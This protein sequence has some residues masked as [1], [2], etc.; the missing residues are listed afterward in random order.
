MAE[1][2]VS[3]NSVKINDLLIKDN[4]TVK[5]INE[6]EEKDREDHLIKSI[7]IG[8]N[9]LRNTITVEKIDYI[10]KEFQRLLTAFSKRTDE[11]DDQISDT[12]EDSVTLMTESMDASLDLEK[13]GNPLYRL[14]KAIDNQITDLRDLIHKKEG[15][16]E[17]IDEESAKGTMKGFDFEDEVVDDL[18]F[19]Q[20]YPDSFEVIGD[21]AEGK[22]R[23]KVGDVLA[24]LQDGRTIAIEVKAGKNYSDRGDK[25]L[26][27]QMDQSMAYRS[28]VGSIAV[29]TIEAMESKVWQNSI[30]LDRGKNRFI[31]AVDR[32]NRDFTM[33]RVAYILLRERILASSE[34]VDT[35]ERKIIDPSKV[36]EIIEDIVRDMSSATKMRQILTDIEGRIFAVKEEISNYQGKV[37]GRVDELNQL[38]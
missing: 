12:M 14:K 35:A 8:I 13:E 34:N 19:W 21:K 38:L 17:G 15:K 33:L 22:T 5:V 28:S 23:R 2:I 37:Q 24:T 36:R 26:D 29:T 1:I 4:D 25:S 6:I 18:N 10:E 20:H 32:E 3:D 11:W 27:S 30:F 7:N 31:V 9:V 16:Q